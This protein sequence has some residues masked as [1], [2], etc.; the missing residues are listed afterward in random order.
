MVHGPD[1]SVLDV[2]RKTRTVPQAIRRALLARDKSCRFPACTSKFCHAHHLEHWADGGETNLSNSALLCNRHHVSVH[3]RGFRVETVE[4]DLRFYHPTGR[5]IHDA[6]RRPSQRDLD[7][8]DAPTVPWWT[9][10]PLN[11]DW[12]MV[13][14]RQ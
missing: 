14:L 10:E 5:L 7:I 4:G 1:G 9:A 11:L 12:A 6:P 3:E 13:V 2:G 8:I